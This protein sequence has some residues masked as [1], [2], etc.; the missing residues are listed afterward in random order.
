MWVHTIKSIKGR[1]RLWEGVSFVME[2]NDKRQH[3]ELSD[4][5]G[6]YDEPSV[7]NLSKQAA[8]FNEMDACRG[9]YGRVL[10][11]DD[12]DFSYGYINP[13]TK[14]LVVHCAT[15]GVYEIPVEIE[16]E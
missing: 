13:M 9:E 5:Y 12:K 14:C 4:I 2:W 16:W 7:K 8:I 15:S 3:R 10:Y 6:V 1:G 11:S